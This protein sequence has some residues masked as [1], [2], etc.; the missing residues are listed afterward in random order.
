M[1]E[2]N[3]LALVAVFV[4][5]SLMSIGGGSAI[6]AGIQNEAVT[7][8]GW[9]TPREFIDLFAIS[10]AAPGPGLMLATLIGWKVG[11]WLGAIGATLALFLPSSLLCY[12]VL[13]MTNAHRDRKWHR[14]VR[15]GLAP[16]GI[17]LMIAGALS[18]F[19]VSGGGAVAALIAISSTAILVWLPRFPAVGVL[20]LG[21]A[22][23]VA[24]YEWSVLT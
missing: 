5:F 10:R 21:G 1:R 15:Q 4:P 17:G 24:L 19:R 18:I 16:V 13:K 22:T 7:V 23:G 9:V 3:L 6:I 8:Q 14:A 20:C 11:G 12:A 2:D